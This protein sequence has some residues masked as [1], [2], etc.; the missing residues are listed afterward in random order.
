MS[1]VEYS[2]HHCYQQVNDL[3]ARYNSRTQAEHCLFDQDPI[4]YEGVKLAHYL[5]ANLQL[6]GR[7]MVSSRPTASCEVL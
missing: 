2:L 3:L 5:S 6:K 1:Q 4:D 7:Q